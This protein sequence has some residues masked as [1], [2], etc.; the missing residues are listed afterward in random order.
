M[1]KNRAL[2]IFGLFCLLGIVSRAIF[3]VKDFTH[4]DEVLY[5][6]GSVDF[7]VRN[8]TPPSPGYFLY[9]MSAKFLNIFTNNPHTSLMA[10]S[11][12]YSGLIAGLVYYFARILKDEVCGII[13]ALLFLTSPLFWYKGVTI[14]G[15][16][17]SG[18]F[19]LLTVLFGWRIIVEKKTNLLFWFSVSFAVL[20]GVRPQEFPIMLPLYIFVLVHLNTKQAMGSI[21]T[22]GL[23][24]CA[25][26]IPLL[27]MSGGLS[28]YISVLKDASGYVAYDSIFGGSFAAKLNNHLVRMTRYFTW[29]YFLGAAPFIYYIG[30]FFYIPNLVNEKKAQFFA[31]WL[32]PALIYNVFIQFGEIGHGMSWGLGFLII[33]AE[34]IIIISEDIV[35]ALLALSRKGVIISGA[36]IRRPYVK[37]AVYALV[38]VPVIIFNCFI[39]FHDFDKDRHDFYDFR[40][41]RQFNYNDVLKKSRFLKSKVDFIKKNFDQKNTAVLVTGT[42]GHQ[43]MYHLPDALIIQAGVIMR[44]D[45]TNFSTWRRLKQEYYENANE[46]IIPEGIQYLVLFDDIFVPYFKNTKDN[47]CYKIDDRHKLFVHKVNPGDRLNFSYQVITIE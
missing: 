43:V 40:K 21:F 5:A 14:F 11:V 36:F 23:V 28:E 2:L 17:N 19:M 1:R 4:L 18:F 38:A 22:F 29:A 6:I 7:S 30:K 44:E 31:V 37:K 32:F 27:I 20:T 3:A 16:L 8:A 13:S 42:F 25:W 12:I 26:L 39:F 10:L 35:E 34:A 47:N 45:H 33:I 9:I 41:Y 46:F 15:Y 24:C